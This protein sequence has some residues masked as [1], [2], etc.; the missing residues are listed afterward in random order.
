MVVVS[1]YTAI[2]EVAMLR[3]FQAKQRALDTKDAIF[4]GRLRLVVKESPSI[5]KCQQ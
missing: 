3:S 1:A 4:V 2:T 5:Q